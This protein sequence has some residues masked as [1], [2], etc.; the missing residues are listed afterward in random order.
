MGCVCGV[1]KAG[2]CE[3][4]VKI[5]DGGLSKTKAQSKEQQVYSNTEG[6]K[7]NDVMVQNFEIWVTES[8]D[9]GWVRFAFGVV[10]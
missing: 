5:A 4:H 7:Y 8:V 3:W 6:E 9:W 10:R 1:G 2:F